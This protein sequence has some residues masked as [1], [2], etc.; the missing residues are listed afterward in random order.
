LVESTAV[1][2]MT[3]R[4]VR[5][6]PA[7]VLVFVITHWLTLSGAVLHSD[8]AIAAE[9]AC[10]E[11]DALAS[12]APD[13]S[14][15]SKQ[16]ASKIRAF[17]CEHYDEWGVAAPLG[18][19]RE[20]YPSGRL[21]LEATYV[22]SLLAGP[23]EIRHE[24]GEL[25][26]RGF[27]VRGEWSGPFEIFHESGAVWFEA[28]FREGRLQGDVRTRY[29]DGALESET[30]FQDGREDGLARSFY[31]TFAGGRLKSEAHIEADQI[32]GVHRILDRNGNLLRSTTRHDGP[33]SWRTR[34]GTQT[35]P[36][37]QSST[38]S[39][40]SSSLAHS[41]VLFRAPKSPRND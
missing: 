2:E 4:P 19:Y 20:L 39:P 3:T 25:F 23:I 41:P 27:L 14:L 29:P 15:R 18:P 1:R 32:I 22:D 8:R 26:A 11:G 31:P 13:P 28:E 36:D 30:R 16:A 38:R 12:G 10:E 6:R 34:L 40:A 24:N 17:W 7:L 37:L 5:R 33:P 9:I 35:A 21:H